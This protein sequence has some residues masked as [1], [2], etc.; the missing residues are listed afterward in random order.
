MKIILISSLTVN[1]GDEFIRFGVEHILRQT[2]PDASMR[3][4]HKVDPRTLFSGF[5]MPEKSPHR[6]VAPFLYRFYA[7]TRGRREE[8]YLESADLVVFAGTPF[9]WRGSA[10]L[11]NCTCANE[12]WIGPTWR[13]LFT[14]IQDTPVFNLA[15]GTSL[16]RPEEYDAI[17]H[18]PLVVKY[19]K[20]AVDR[21]EITTARDENT[22]KL[23]GELG[24]DIELIPCASLLC[25]KGA[26]IEARKPEYVAINLM[27]AAAPRGR[28]HDTRESHWI[29]VAQQ[30]IPEIEKRHRIMF[31]SHA[32]EEHE[33]AER[34]FPGRERFF[35]KDPIALLKVYSKALYGMCNRVHGTAAIATFGRPAICIGGDQ[36]NNLIKQ[37][38]LPAYDHRQIDKPLLLAAI[39]ELERNYDSYVARLKE[40]SDY[41]ER[42]YLRVVRKHSAVVAGKGVEIPA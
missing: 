32:A 10:R 14:E 15:A 30:V 41:S 8:N 18:D 34:Y 1:P 16:F 29:R 39:D 2:F 24:Y 31:V 9:I 5:K 21:T 20:S 3:T 42:A 36:R 25:S 4:I 27:P 33:A 22:R 35:S 40:R 7:M 37:F 38:G 13:R 17:L 6:L 12:A 26:G 23:L 19:L 28:G 11:F